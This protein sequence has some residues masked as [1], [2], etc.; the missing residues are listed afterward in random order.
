M[1]CGMSRGSNHATELAEIHSCLEIQGIV[2]LTLKA[3]RLA[4]QSLLHSDYLL[5]PC[6]VVLTA[7]MYPMSR[8]SGVMDAEQDEKQATELY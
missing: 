4:R 3:S 6:L 8:K 1:N 2:A 5:A 7:H